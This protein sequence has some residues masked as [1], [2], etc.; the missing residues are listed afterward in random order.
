MIVIISKTVIIIIKDS[1]YITDSNITKDSSN[2]LLLYF[3][4]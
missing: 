2:Y 4:S 1:N 3:N